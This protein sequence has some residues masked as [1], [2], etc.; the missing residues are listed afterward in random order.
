MLTTDVYTRI[1][2]SHSQGLRPSLRF[3]QYF[4]EICGCLQFRKIRTIN[5]GWYMGRLRQKQLQLPFWLGVYK[6]AFKTPENET[7]GCLETSGTKYL[8]R[9]RHISELIPALGTVQWLSRLQTTF[10][11]QFS[12]SVNRRT[13]DWDGLQSFQHSSSCD[14]SKTHDSWI[15]LNSLPFNTTYYLSI[16][17]SFTH[18]KTTTERPGYPVGHANILLPPVFICFNPTLRS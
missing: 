17:H 10:R 5:L 2:N 13:A 8:E 11:Q 7:I 16:P 6:W 3:L 1:C 14:V 18:R 4:V 15:A 12:L 9:Q